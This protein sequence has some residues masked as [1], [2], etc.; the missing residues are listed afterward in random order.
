MKA[1]VTFPN[2][3]AYKKRWLAKISGQV[4]VNLDEVGRFVVEQAKGLA[5]VGTGRLRDSITYIIEVKDGRPRCVVGAPKREF[6]AIYQELGTKSQPAH[7]FL[8]PAVYQNA[9][10]I[11][12]ILREGR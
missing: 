2:W 11:I 6:Y 10:E 1:K 9:K 3:D 12:R 7:P 4:V 5:P 8:R